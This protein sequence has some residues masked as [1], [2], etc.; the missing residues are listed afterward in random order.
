M[1]NKPWPLIHR[2]HRKGIGLGLILVIVGPLQELLAPEKT[3]N[4]VTPA[5]IQL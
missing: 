4:E 5:P 2:R 3:T 1:A